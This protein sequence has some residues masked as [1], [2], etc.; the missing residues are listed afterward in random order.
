MQIQKK[1]DSFVGQLNKEYLEKYY[2]L[3]LPP[4]QNSGFWQSVHTYIFVDNKR[5]L[6][7]PV[8][9]CNLF[10]SGNAEFI[11]VLMNYY[12]IKCVCVHTVV[13]DS[14][15]LVSPALW[16]DSLPI[17]PSGK[18]TKCWNVIKQMKFASQAGINFS[19]PVSSS[20]GDSFPA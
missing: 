7:L 5:N 4:N 18:F 9:Y 10:S 8:N 6:P 1:K 20:Y 16:A 3:P 12:N 11:R 14:L 2:S 15:S 13:S 19:L 17:E